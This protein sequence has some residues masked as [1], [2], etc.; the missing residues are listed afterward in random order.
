MVKDTYFPWWLTVITGIFFIYIGWHLLSTPAI[1]TLRLM[2]LL[3]LYWL[4]AGV[5]D[6]V[7]LLFDH[8]RGHIALRLAGSILGIVAGIIILNNAVVSTIFTLTF[9]SYFI[10]FAFIFNGVVHMVMGNATENRKYKWSWGSLLLGL[11]YLVFGLLVVSGP[12]IVTSAA[13]VWLTG[14]FAIIGGIVAIASAFM[15][16]N[17]APAK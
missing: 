7:M 10:G 16:R 8:S 12:T 9:I 6:I 11:V 2:Q 17:T 4:V 15:F 5:V 1:T 13:F 3:G 14:F